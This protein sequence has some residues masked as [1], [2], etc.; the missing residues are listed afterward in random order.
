[1]GISPLFMCSWHTWG[2]HGT[3]VY[4]PSPGHTMQ[5]MLGG[6]THSSSGQSCL[7]SK[8]PRCWISL[9]SACF[10][11]QSLWLALILGTPGILKTTT[12]LLTEPEDNCYLDPQVQGTPS[13]SQRREVLILA[14]R[15]GDRVCSFLCYSHISLT[16]WSSFSCTFS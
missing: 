14:S 9:V 8:L 2:R 15:F 11:P 3:R 6:G 1:M 12:P 13:F 5:N 4:P 16:H 10:Q 7:L